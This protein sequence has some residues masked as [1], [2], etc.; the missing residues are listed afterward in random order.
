LCD[1]YPCGKYDG[2]DLSD[3]FITHKNQFRDFE[4]AKNIGLKAYEIELSK[5]VKALEYML[6]NYDDGRR[7]SFFCTAV[8]LLDLQDINSVIE[9]IDGDE[10]KSP[11]KMKAASAVHLLEEIAAKKGVSLKLRKKTKP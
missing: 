10:A 6:K 4:K 11:Q 9:Q 8:N 3:S 5:K 1:E 2:A 7:K